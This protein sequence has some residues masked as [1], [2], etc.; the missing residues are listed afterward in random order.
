MMTGTPGRSAPALMKEAV[1][2]DPR[3]Y[4]PRDYYVRRGEYLGSAAGRWALGIGTAVLIGL[5]LIAS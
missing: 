1:M 3:N 4:D 5:L 2:T